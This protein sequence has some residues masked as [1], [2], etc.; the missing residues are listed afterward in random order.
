M[1]ILLRKNIFHLP[2]LSLI[3]IEPHKLHTQGV[4]KTTYETLVRKLGVPHTMDGKP[5][6]AAWWFELDD[7]TPFSIYCL[8][9]QIPYYLFNWLVRAATFGEYNNVRINFGLEPVTFGPELQIKPK[10]TIKPNET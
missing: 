10:P 3:L 5:Y 4:I 9:D 7:G 2:R 1:S 6:S 8:E